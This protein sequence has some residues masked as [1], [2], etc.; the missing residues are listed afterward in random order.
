MA[1]TIWSRFGRK[2]VALASV[3]ALVILALAV[4]LVLAPPPSAADAAQQSERVESAAAA[5]PVPLPRGCGGV[6]PPQTPACC[7]FGYIYHDEVPVGDVT[8]QIESPQGTRIVTTTSGIESSHPYY[9]VDLSSAPLLV[10]TGEVITITAS[11]GGMTS[12]RAWTVQGGGQQVDLGL[13]DGYAMDM[14]PTAPGWFDYGDAGAEAASDETHWS[15]DFEAATIDPV[16]T[17]TEQYG[18]I[19]V[20]TEQAQSGSQAVKL[21]S[22]SG[23]QREIHLNRSFSA[24]ITGTASIWFYDSAPGL[25][26]LYARFEL[27]ISGSSVAVV[28]IQDYDGSFYHANANGVAP[29]AVASRSL[30]WHLFEIDTANGV[31]RIDGSEVI[32]SAGSFSFDSI[33]LNVTGPSGRPDATYYFDDLRVDSVPDVQFDSSAYS[34]DENESAAILTVTL[35]ATSTQTIT[36]DYATSDGT[37][38]AGSDYTAA[39]STLTFTPGTDLITFTVPIT[40]DVQDELDETV[41]LALRD[42]ANAVPG[43]LVTATLTIVDDD[44]PDF[45]D[46]SAVLTDVYGGGTWGDYDNDGDLDILLAGCDADTIF[47][48]ATI[49]RNDGGA[50]VDIHAGLGEGAKDA[51]WGDY[52]GDNDLDVLLVGGEPTCT[53]RIYRNDGGGTFTDIGAGLP[54]NVGSLA[55]GDYDNDGDLDVL[56][57]SNTGASYITE[58][59]RNDDGDTFTDIDAGLIGVRGGSVAWGDYDN[60]GDL[61]I[62]LTGWTGSSTTA[63]VYRNDGEGTFVDINAGL[64]G[65]YMSDAVW[66]DYDNDGDLDILRTGSTGSSTQTRLYRNNGDGTFTDISTSLTAVE[67]SDVAW[68]DYD[69]DGDLDVLLSGWSYSGLKTEIHRNDGGGT[70]THI[71]AG[72]TGIREGSV[73]WGDYDNDGD[74]DILLTGGTGSAVISR[75]YRNDSAVSNTVP[76]APT[77]LAASVDGSTV[78]LGWSA[79][80]DA[81]TP[82]D[83]LTYNLRVGTTPGGAQIS[84]PMA[85]TSTG[86]RRVAAMGG[87]NHGLTATLILSPGTYYWSVQAV[88]AAFA[89]SAFASEGSFAIVGIPDVQFSS[90]AS[91]VDENEG[92]VT[93]TVTLSATSTESITVEYITSDG[94]AVAGSDYITTSGV[95][96]FAP[97][98]TSRT[99]AV[100][101]INDELNEPDQAFTVTLSNPSN[102][103]LGTLDTVTV[104]IVDED[105][106]WIELA[107]AGGAPPYPAWNA[108]PINYDAANNRLIAFFPGNPPYNPDPPGNGNEVWI[109]THANGLGGTPTWSK[110][111]PTGT[112][113]ASNWGESAVYDAVTNRLIVYG[114]CVANCGSTRSDVFVLTHANGLGGS[115]VWSQITVTN[116]QDRVNHS[117]LYNSANDLMI[118]FGG[119]HGSYG[120]DENDIRLLSNAV[121]ITSPSTWTALSPTGGP[122]GVRS[123]HTAIYDQASNRMTV[124]GG[125]ELI[126]A[127]PY[128]HYEYNDLWVLSD[129][130]GL[131]TPTWTQLTPSGDLPFPRQAHSAVYDS[132]NNRMLVYGGSNFSETTQSHTYLGD[133]WELTGSNGLDGTPAWSQ[134]SSS[135]ASPGPRAYHTAAMDVANQRMIVFGGQDEITTTNRIWVLILPQPTL[136]PG[137]PTPPGNVGID[138]PATGLVGMSNTFTATVTPPTATLPITYVWLA[139]GQTP[140]LNTGGDLDD[141]VS[142]TWSTAGTQYITV[143]VTNAGGAFTATWSI[144]IADNIVPPAEVTVGG[145]TTGVVGAAATFT[146]DVSP[147]TATLPITYEWYATGQSPVVHTGG[148]LDD[149]ISFT[150]STTGTQHV[151]VTAIN[152]GGAFT[153]TWSI[154]ITEYT[155]PS[156]AFT[157]LPLSGTVPLDVQFTDESTG[158]AVSW[159]WAFGDGGVSGARHPAYEYVVTGTYTV[160]LTVTGPGG[161]D[162]E[163]KTDYISVLPPTT[164]TFMLYFAADNNLHTHL[165]DAIDE[166]E[167]VAYKDNVN[168]L[169]LWDGAQT[170]DTRLYHVQYDLGSGVASPIESVVWNP[171]E[172]GLDDSLTLVNFVNWSRTTYPADHYLLSIANHG[173]GTSGIAWDDTSPVTENYLLAYSELEAALSS[174]TSGGSDKIDVL[175]LDACLMGLI[176]DAYEVKDYVDYAVASE[177]LGWSVFAYDDYVASIGDDTTPEELATSIADAYF[178]ALQGYPGTVAALDM[179]AIG[180]VGSATD[181]LAQALI[182]YMDISNISQVIGI[183]NKVQ[184]FD[185]R[186]YLTLD[187]S[188]EYID[189]YDF[190]EWVKSDISDAAVQNA[191]RGVMDAITACIVAEHHQTGTDPWS[192]NTWDLDDAHGI[193]IYF[194]P[195]SGGWDYS[196][197]IAGGSWGF[198][199]GT[200]WDEFLVAYFSMSGLPPETP[201]NPGMPPMQGVERIYL[202]FV[203]RKE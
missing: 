134:P 117:A 44:E 78:T 45:V 76:S 28:H 158:E 22:T 81:Q 160:S 58:I 131:G 71:N 199:A 177:N 203:V 1:H 38:A 149:E 54:D 173:R 79:S 6:S 75:I 17:L 142:F 106:H 4:L 65:A 7:M 61:D 183:R 74:L 154:T 127:L 116:P 10:S 52:D 201:E 29:G 164:W 99:L 32:T 53:L 60:D 82:S 48:S 40:N 77:G 112:P 20:T 123:G 141:V 2:G 100:P 151:T 157:A 162:T 197:Y 155:A 125:V 33:D 30:G 84:S 190:A 135:G 118:V 43:T 200:A 97:G 187:S 171:G 14:L 107:P 180:D 182:T 184:T 39:S 16:W 70:F 92:T 31:V 46:A 115:P 196:N 68:G 83:G 62:L 72:L 69:N 178:S 9:V 128:N 114:G 95:L 50:F 98:S 172:L 111:E 34:V 191:A 8:V 163:I 101:I 55:W 41:D 21:S 102:A 159:D 47:C 94:T 138:G 146:A 85:S 139:T 24:P 152:A 148:D 202:P 12:S 13:V 35:S 51:A 36:V 156:A 119:Q 181:A 63:R 113:P 15:D 80:N 122:P 103:V 57:A 120:T 109:L 143:T 89:G 153:A 56:M 93:L 19:T 126:S 87:V 86:Y 11:Y 88:D 168:I 192:G 105:Y 145:S 129:A 166:M 37:A 140:V 25:Q 147:P 5:P 176:E 185:S 59:Y 167:R 179:S 110:L 91:S 161:T 150:W 188:D 193:A 144:S 169:V 67:Y 170:G 108:K 195:T 198:C 186:D 165:E 26:T 174:A 124:F 18:T 42:P 137:S 23:G 66:G 64:T 130:N 194:P 96:T 90:S 73:A 132:A 121:G 27:R 49:Y 3:L 175:F 136:M 189:L 133:L 104:T